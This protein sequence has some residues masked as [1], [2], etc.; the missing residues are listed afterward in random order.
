MDNVCKEHQNAMFC[1]H[2]KF[3]SMYFDLRIFQ[4]VLWTILRRKICQLYS[5]L[6]SSSNEN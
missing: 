3:A 4:T 1:Q 2:M 5:V 6:H